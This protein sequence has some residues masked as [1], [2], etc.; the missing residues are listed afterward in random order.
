MTLT[1]FYMTRGSFD[2]LLESYVAPPRMPLDPV[3]RGRERHRMPCF[4]YIFEIFGRGRSQ[5]PLSLLVNAARVR[6][7][8]L[9]GV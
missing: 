8:E 4:S 2:V 9:D 5:P 7:M 1:N 3:T 6:G